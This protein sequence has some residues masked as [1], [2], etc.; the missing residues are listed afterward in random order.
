MIYVSVIGSGRVVGYSEV[1][2]NSHSVC[3]SGPRSVH[4]RGGWL[5]SRLGVSQ[6]RV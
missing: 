6:H 3:G 2:Q 1:S 4:R 5:H